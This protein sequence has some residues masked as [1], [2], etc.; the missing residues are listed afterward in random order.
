[1]L[2]AI[3]IATTLAT[4]NPAFIF[5]FIFFTFQK[6]ITT[7]AIIDEIDFMVNHKKSPSLGLFIR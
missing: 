1:M 2:A 3:D 5:K 6:F 7:T 4:T